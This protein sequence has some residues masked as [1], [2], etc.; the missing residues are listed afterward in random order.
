MR[1]S[2]YRRL[3]GGFLLSGIAILLTCLLPVSIDFQRVAAVLACLSSTL[4]GAGAVASVLLVVMTERNLIARMIKTGHY[5]RLVNNIFGAGTA[6]FLLLVVSIFS[7]FV[8]GRILLYLSHLS[9]LI[10]VP[11]FWWCLQSGWRF[12]N[13]IVV[14]ISDERR[15]LLHESFFSL[16]QRPHH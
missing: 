6:L 8:E 10:A 16:T 1:T 5:R 15:R 7:L 11:A 2:S 14:L 3:A 12:Y 13:V 4:L 9:V